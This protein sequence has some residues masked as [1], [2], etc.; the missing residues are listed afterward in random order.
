MREEEVK[1]EERMKEYM[2]SKF[3][4]IKSDLR[5]NVTNN[6][7]KIN[8]KNTYKTPIKHTK[9][10]RI[11]NSPIITN[12][13]TLP[14]YK[15]EI[16]PI[17][18]IKG[19]SLEVERLSRNIVTLINEINKQKETIG[20]EYDKLKESSYNDNSISSNVRKIALIGQPEYE[21]R[22]IYSISVFVPIK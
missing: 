10:T 6:N 20:K 18:E 12:L 7:P 5:K 17:K 22:D 2:K 11:E 9:V 1:D 15:R 14:K 13:S 4:R 21:D 8:I 19:D 3:R 16:L